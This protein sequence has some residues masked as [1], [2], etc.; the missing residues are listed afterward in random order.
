MPSRSR[1]AA[2]GRPEPLRLE[3]HHQGIRLVGLR[4]SSMIVI[5]CLSGLPFGR[6][7][8]SSCAGEI[9]FAVGIQ[10]ASSAFSNSLSHR[11]EMLDPWFHGPPLRSKIFRRSS[12]KMAANLPSDVGLRTLFDVMEKHR[13]NAVIQG[14]ACEA[15][16]ELSSRSEL[17]QVTILEIGMDKVCCRCD[18]PH[19]V[20]S[21]V[22]LCNMCESAERL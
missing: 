19:K 1:A 9:G 17:T 10:R 3:H 13:N 8:L 16:L 20:D 6:S 5:M 18:P 11:A 14:K 12:F 7:A 21:F 2:V 4:V 22:Y 15:L